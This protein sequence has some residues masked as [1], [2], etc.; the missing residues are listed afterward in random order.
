M[1]TKN[2]NVTKTLKNDDYLFFLSSV[3]GYENISIFWNFHE[4]TCDAVSLI[5]SLSMLPI[6]EKVMAH[7]FLSIWTGNNFGFDL[8][9]DISCLSHDDIGT[10]VDW[11]SKPYLFENNIS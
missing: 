7:F 8:F 5:N 6:N 3:A 2:M 1:T 9:K 10:I 4:G 11:I